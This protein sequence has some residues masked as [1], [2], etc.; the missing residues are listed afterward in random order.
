MQIDIKNRWTGEVIFSG[1]YESIKAAAEAAGVEGK[2]LSNADLS[3]ANL[4]NANLRNA[5]LRDANLSNADLRDANLSN[6][7]LSNADLSDADLS[8]AN[9]SNANLRN[10]NLSDADLSDA[11]LSNAKLSNA[12]LSAI[13]ADFIAEVLKLPFELEF[14]RSALVDGEVDGSTYSGECACLA[15]TLAHAKG[16]SR[17]NGEV[18]E[19]AVPFTANASSPRE[20]FFLAIREGDTPE[21]NPASQIALEWTDEAIR[22]RD[23]IVAQANKKGARKR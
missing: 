16:I 19:G 8:N 4:S 23:A 7:K 11:Y 20:R 2:S 21:T 1:D 17:Y 22:M 10:A 18:I 15:G 12:N 5:N 9:L 14:L 3:N 6:A 13:K